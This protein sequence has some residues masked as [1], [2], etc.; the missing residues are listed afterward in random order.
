MFEN[1]TINDLKNI[2]AGSVIRSNEKPFL[3]ANVVDAETFLLSGYLIENGAEHTIKITDPHLNFE[4]VPLG[5]MCLEQS[6]AD[7]FTYRTPMRQ[8]RVGLGSETF[9]YAIPPSGSLGEAHRMK[10]R[11]SA[12]SIKRAVSSAKKNIALNKCIMGIFPSI[13]K[14][15]ETIEDGK[16]SLVAVSRDF[17]IDRDYCLFFRTDMVGIVTENGNPQFSRGRSYLQQ[18]WEKIHAG[19]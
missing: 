13:E 4:P 19:V 3:V 18:F 15:F 10:A 17:A 16:K 9:Q 11:D 12:H 1:T 14:A 6:P 2:L 8:Y 5:Y 7:V